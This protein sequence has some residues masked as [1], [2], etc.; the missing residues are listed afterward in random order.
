MWRLNNIGQLIEPLALRIHE[1][2]NGF[3]RNKKLGMTSRNFFCHIMIKSLHAHVL[4]L[5]QYLKSWKDAAYERTY[6][7]S[8]VFFSGAKVYRFQGTQLM[9][10]YPKNL[11]EE[12]IVPKHSKIPK[13]IDAG[14]WSGF[15]WDVNFDFKQF[16]GT[17]TDWH[18]YSLDPTFG[19][20]M[21][22]NRTSF[23]SFGFGFLKSSVNSINSPSFIVRN[24]LLKTECCIRYRD[25]GCIWEINKSL[26]LTTKQFGMEFL[27][28]WTLL[29]SIKKGS[30]IL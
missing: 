29:S 4:S 5:K 9:P 23:P 26:V 21:N 27:Q 30:L 8:I 20:L 15:Y 1:F 17:K 7:G 16:I 10:N 14:K 12:F 24:S 28:T 22:I 11:S 18:I 3:P 13:R 25:H 2:W 19:K 6:D